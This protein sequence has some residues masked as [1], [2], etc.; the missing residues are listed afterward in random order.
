MLSSFIR[1]P[2]LLLATVALLILT[3]GHAT[4]VLAGTGTGTGSGNV[5]ITTDQ[6]QYNVGDI[7]KVCYTVLGAGPVTILDQHPDGTSQQIVNGNDDGTGDC[8]EALVT[9]PTGN[10]CLQLNDTS[11]GMT[12]SAQTCF[13]VQQDSSSSGSSQPAAQ[14]CGQVNVLGGQ[15]TSSGSAGIES[16]FYQ[17]V[18]S[19]TPATLEVSI[20]GVDAGIKHTFGLI[21]SGGFCAIQD[22][23]QHF[24]VPRPPGPTTTTVCTGLTQ[25]SGGGLDFMDC[26]GT[27]I[28][29]PAGS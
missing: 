13:Q 22:S 25:T 9:P 6:P 23:Q 10:E 8:F 29:V 24:V 14:D 4:H 11:G 20:S 2:A 18:M 15:V 7:A 27:D 17:A 1:R 16:C 3:A 21:Y 28:Q 19:C 12:G 26:G 5:T